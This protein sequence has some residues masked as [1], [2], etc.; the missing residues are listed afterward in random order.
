M[1][2]LTVTLNAAIDKRYDL[3]R[4]GV[5]EVH[6]VTRVQAS[7]GGKGLNVAR[8][9]LLCGQRVVATGFVAGFAGQFVAGRVA[10]EGIR[11]EFIRVAGETRTCI[12]VIDADGTSTEFLEPGVTV[13]ASDVAALQ[14]RFEELLPDVDAV[15][16]SGSVPAGCPAEVYL[17]LIVAAKRAGKPVILDTSGEPLRAALAAAP[18]AIKP[19]RAEL[20][21]LVG[22]TLESLADV[23]AAARSLCAAGPHWVVVSLGS[24]GAVAVSAGSAVHVAAPCVTAVNPVGCGDVLVAG[25]A[26]GL[27]SGLELDEALPLA[28]RISAAAAAH[29]ET[30]RFD[31][32]VAAGL[33]SVVSVLGMDR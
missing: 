24:D 33:S 23:A 20:G 8:G 7:A 14:R 1:T 16:I 18:T 21:A 2:I 3:A 11:D 26:T 15:T 17:P 32:A 28:V 29:Q 6:R 19:N 22:S 10:E 13:T 30:G 12:N 4:I 25:L 5:G 9:A 27:A 31:P